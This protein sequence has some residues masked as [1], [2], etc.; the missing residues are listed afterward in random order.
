M[1]A[2][3]DVCGVGTVLGLVCVL[4]L[5]GVGCVYQICTS[6]AVNGVYTLASWS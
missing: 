3:Y 2:Q 6:W 1:L 5:Q 4:A